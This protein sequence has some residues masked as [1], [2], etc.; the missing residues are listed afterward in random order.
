MSSNG[1]AMLCQRN[2]AKHQLKLCVPSYACQL[3]DAAVCSPA[4]SAVCPM[5][6][7]Q[8]DI[9][10]C[11]A[12]GLAVG[13]ASLS[14]DEQLTSLIALAMVLHKMP[15]AIGLTSYLRGRAWPLGKALKALLIFASASPLVALACA[16]VL[17]AIPSLGSSPQVCY[18]KLVA[19]VMTALTFL[20]LPGKELTRHQGVGR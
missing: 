13:A 11:S 15:T 12:D 20:N 6:F 8:E 1:P 14:T 10:I 17:T 9:V 3:A 16:A 7:G 18:Q 2:E 4:K 19:H 5:I